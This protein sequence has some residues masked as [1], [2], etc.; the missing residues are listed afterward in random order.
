MK[1]LGMAVAVALLAGLTLTGQAAEDAVF[2]DL[3]GQP[4]TLESFTGGGKWLVVM[5][6]ASDCHVCNQEV[7]E[8]VRFHQAHKDKDA[9]VLGISIDGQAKLADAQ[10]FIK[11]HAVPFPNLIAEPETAMLYYMMHTQAA[12]AGT[13]T[14]MVYDPDGRLQAAQA[15]AVPPEIIEDF[16]AKQAGAKP[17]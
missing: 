15:G 14:I 9:S 5:L 4:R 2:T 12:F 1:R 7:G 8:Y 11:R 3:A 16:I 6:W 10:D 17:G 13:P